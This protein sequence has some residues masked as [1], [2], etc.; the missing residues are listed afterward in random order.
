M[1]NA[2]RRRAVSLT[3]AAALLSY[4]GAAAAQAGAATLTV[5]RPCYVQVSG[6]PP[7]EFSGSGYRAGDEVVLTSPDGTVDVSVKADANGNIAGS[8]DPPAPPFSAPGQ[9]AETITALDQDAAATIRAQARVLVAVRGWQ[10]GSVKAARGY[11]ALTETTNWSFSG[12][13][14][15]Q[16]IF[17]H[18]LYH[19]RLVATA[20]FGIAEGPCGVLKV[21][22]RLYP[23]TPHHPGYRVQYDDS[24]TYSSSSQPRILGPISLGG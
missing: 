23:A 22:A 20:R 13:A 1:R 12:F 11:R 5:D 7:M 8:A 18:Y 10:H 21:R 24:R 3:V 14:P 9:K 2:V 4:S 19:G 15:S 17:G 6:S 16:P